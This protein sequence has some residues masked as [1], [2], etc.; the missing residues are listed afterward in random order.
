[1]QLVTRLHDDFLRRMISFYRTDGEVAPTD[2]AEE[3]F[4][5]LRRAGVRVGL[6]TGF[7]RDIVDVIL[8]RLGWTGTRVID[9]SVASDEVAHG[10]PAPDLILE[11]MR[12]AGVVSPQQV[13]KAGDTPADLLE[14]K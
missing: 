8:Q 4:S 14:G 11:S 5:E 6:D 1:A 9:F 10:R 13:A 2:G 3:V 7:S 12:R